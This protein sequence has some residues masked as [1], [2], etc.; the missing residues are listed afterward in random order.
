MAAEY[1]YSCMKNYV[2]EYL[3]FLRTTH[4]AEV[5]DTYYD[6]LFFFTELLYHREMCNGFEDITVAMTNSKL[7]NFYK[8]NTDK[9]LTDKDCKI[10]LKSFFNYLY[11]TYGI[12][13]DKVM[14]GLE[15]KN[16]V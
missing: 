8:R 12:K 10:I 6:V 4:S 14:K 1:F 3:A 7:R 2:K 16:N 5:V 11:D 15:K 9:I 13:C